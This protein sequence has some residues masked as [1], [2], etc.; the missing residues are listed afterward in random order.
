[1]R[2]VLL[3]IAF[4]WVATIVNLSLQWLISYAWQFGHFPQ[5]LQHVQQNVGIFCAMS[6]GTLAG[7]VVKYL[8]DKQHIFA[9]TTRNLRH[10]GQTF[11]RY[12]LMGVVT[13]LLF[14]IFELAFHFIFHL[15]VMRYVGA[16]I[17]LLLG[18]WLKYRLDQHF[19]FTEP[20]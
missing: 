19:V 13:T 16:V 9:Y 2:K 18:Y 15:E 7:L 6:G 14:W 20:K 12:S 11:I 10:N 3:Y 4:A 17:G 8:L 5:S 1:M